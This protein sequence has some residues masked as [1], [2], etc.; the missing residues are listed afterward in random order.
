MKFQK[1]K[2]PAEIASIIKAKSVGTSSLAVTGINEIHQVEQ[3]DI[4]FVD[5][6]KYYNKAISSAATF[7]I[8]DKE[9]PCPENKMLFVSANPFLDYVYL[10]RLFRPFEA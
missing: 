1:A 9:V 5:H 8:I 7:I 4:T 2:S 10:V 6:E 3:G